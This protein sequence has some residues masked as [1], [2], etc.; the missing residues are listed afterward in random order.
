[1]DDRDLIKQDA[2]YPAYAKHVDKQTDTIDSPIAVIG[3]IQ[4]DLIFKGGRH[5]SLNTY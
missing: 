2:Y 1:M 5:F 3:D 4:R